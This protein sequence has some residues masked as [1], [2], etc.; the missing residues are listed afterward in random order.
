MADAAIASS[1]ELARRPPSRDELPIPVADHDLRDVFDLPLGTGES[2]EK[3]AVSSSRPAVSDAEA[4]FQDE[5]A[6]K[7][8][9][10]GAEARSQS[11]RC[12][13][14]G[15]VIPMGMS[16]CASCGVD[17]E[18]GMRVGLEDDLAPPLPSP[19]T[20]PPLHIAIIGFLCGLAGG[21]LLIY[22]LIQ[23][24]RDGAGVTQYGW[25]CLALVCAFGI[26]GSVQFFVGK[27]PR[28]LMLA[29]T[30]GVLV[31]LAA[32]VAAPIYR[33]HFETK[34][35][36]IIPHSP[37]KPGQTGSLDDENMEIKSVEELLDQHKINTGLILVGIYVILSIY[38][39]SPPVKRYFVRQAALNSAPIP[40]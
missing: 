35:R 1:H 29:L 11:R 5:P 15:G 30:L 14:C 37:S 25:L 19:S 40:V 36:V 22:S 3:A 27:S 12:S 16:V 38:L 23:S 33:A 21:V 20:A 13:H 32:L 39:M 10:R 2:I 4:L 7:R 8:K 17:Q 9:P 31:N 34:E 6:L 24:V 28:Y 18:T 26:F